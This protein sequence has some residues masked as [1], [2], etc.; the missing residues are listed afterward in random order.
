MCIRDS[1]NTFLNY[2]AVAPISIAIN[3]SAN[4]FRYYQT[5][6]IKGATSK[7][8]NHA[9]LAVG[10]DETEKYTK[11]K[12]SWGEDWG[13]NGYFRVAIVS[14]GGPI[15]VYQEPSFPVYKGEPVP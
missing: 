2:L 6:I 15:G 9:V 14:G 7:Q 4:E 12:N 5:G 1:T 10:Y 8:L 3:A 13:E 11:G